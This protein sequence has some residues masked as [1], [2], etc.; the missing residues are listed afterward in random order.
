MIGKDSR[1]WIEWAFPRSERL[2]EFA[3]A[4]GKDPADYNS[5]TNAFERGLYGDPQM[6][7]VAI[8]YLADNERIYVNPVDHALLQSAG[9]DTLFAMAFLHSFGP[10]CETGD[11]DGDEEEGSIRGL[12]NLI[13]GTLENPVHK[14][15]L[16]LDRGCGLWQLQMNM[17]LDKH[18]FWRSD[19]RGNFGRDE[20]D[21]L[22]E[23][24][25]PASVMA[26]MINQ[27]LK[28]VIQHPVL[29]RFSLEIENVHGEDDD[30]RLDIETGESAITYAYM[31]NEIEAQEQGA[32]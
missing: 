30:T 17:R 9:I 8:D 6:R 16:S 22:L 3:V 26:G 29:D 11:W 19:F 28:T 20:P 23:R 1:E 13:S 10:N 24:Q 15:S 21:I 31:V 27:P 5:T 18:V 7:Q 14:A 4:L 25:F 32:A 2:C 12:L